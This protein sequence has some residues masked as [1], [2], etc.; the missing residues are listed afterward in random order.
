[1]RS[2]TWNYARN[3]LSPQ[4]RNNQ[5]GNQ[6]QHHIDQREREQRVVAVGPVVDQAAAPGAQ[7]RSEAA[8]DRDGAVDGSNPLAAKDVQRGRRDQRTARADH[9][10]EADDEAGQ[11]P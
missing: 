2:S 1:M 9:A 5:E 11:Q 4:S 3:R 7:S 10:A 6:S 8:A